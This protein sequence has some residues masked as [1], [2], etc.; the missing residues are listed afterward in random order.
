MGSQGHGSVVM[1]P[2][3]DGTAKK[4]QNADCV[5]MENF[6]GQGHGPVI[7]SPVEK[8]AENVPRA[9]FVGSYMAAGGLETQ[10]RF[11]GQQG[12]VPVTLP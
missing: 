10:I 1:D 4:A 9:P 3:M 2:P 7:A 12:S 6:E 8:M 11:S 5:R